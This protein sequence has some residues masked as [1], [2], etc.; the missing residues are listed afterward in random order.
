[1][2]GRDVNLGSSPLMTIIFG[3]LVTDF[4]DYFKPGSTVTKAEFTHSVDT[5]W[6]VH[7]SPSSRYWLGLQ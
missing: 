3:Q 7:C 1:M 2:T 5:M 4:T 6:F